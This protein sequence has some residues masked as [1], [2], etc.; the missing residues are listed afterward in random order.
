MLK[1]TVWL[2][3]LG[4][5]VAAILGLEPASMV[6]VLAFSIVTI[7]L[8]NLF[9][10]SGHFLA[11]C[12]LGQRCRRFVVGPLELTRTANGWKGRFQDKW[13]IGSVRLQPSS[14]VRFRLQMGI[15]LIAGPLGSIL[16]GVTFA[17]LAQQVDDPLMR[18]FWNFSAAWAGTMALRSLYPF[19]HGT[20]MSDGYQLLE[21]S[22][23]G[24]AGIDAM[25]RRMLAASSHATALRP[26]DWPRD[27]ILRLAEAPADGR[28]HHH[29]DRTPHHNLYLA[30]VHFLDCGDVPR[31]KPYL[32]RLLA[33]WRS[34]DPPEYALEAAYFLGFH[35]G[36]PVG[37]RK[38]LN[39]EARSV[40]PWV[41]G[42]AAAAVEQANGFSDKAQELVLQAL[43]AVR[44]AQ[45]CGA[46]QYE[47]DLLESL[48]QQTVPG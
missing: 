29:K 47:I 18:W 15:T 44:S 30:Y 25:Q 41:R 46:Q 13:S 28:V 9:H 20:Q 24:G 33:G 11:G 43:A 31:A 19:R 23:L 17:W 16:A 35:D 2:A 10:E 8:S 26:R 40:D 42:R 39:A 37:S 36:D 22:L 7:P 34:D 4:F 5:S 1:L 38:W 14:F 3:F 27:L 32:E 6:A 48:L 45:P 12:A 21:I